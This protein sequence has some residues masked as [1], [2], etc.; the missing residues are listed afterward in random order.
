MA[1][2]P[3]SGRSQ[4]GDVPLRPTPTCC[5]CIV[6]GGRI[7]LIQR[8]HEPSKGLWSFPG[9]RIGFG[10]RVVDAV[11][12]EVLEETG[13]TVE[14]GEIFQ[15]YDWIVEGERGGVDFHY[16]VNYLRC[17]Y[18]SGEPRAASDALQVR[19]V[20]ASEIPGLAMHPFVRQTALTLLSAADA[21]GP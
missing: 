4:T 15:V 19:W 10:E 8:A 1:D 14:P 11:K 18:I 6:W 5:A 21:A 2:M 12:R 13:V 20:A 7:L 16:V 17:R 3:R 9:G